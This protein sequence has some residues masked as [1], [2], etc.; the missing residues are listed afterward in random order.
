MTVEGVRGIANNHQYFAL[1]VNRVVVGSEG[2]CEAA[3]VARVG[4]LGPLPPLLL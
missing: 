3:K 2:S 4:I 1:R